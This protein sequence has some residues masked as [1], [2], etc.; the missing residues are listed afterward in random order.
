MTLS[1]EGDGVGEVVRKIQTLRKVERWL[2]IF[3]RFF[4]TYP[5]QNAEQR[6]QRHIRF[7]WE[8]DK[9]SVNTFDRNHWE[10]RRQADMLQAQYRR[11]VKEKKYIFEE[12]SNSQLFWVGDTFPT[13]T[14]RLY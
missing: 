12:D 5:E 7:R 11:L 6:Q 14:V 1:K 9:P 2:A 10:Q 4:S 8:I 13:V 3:K